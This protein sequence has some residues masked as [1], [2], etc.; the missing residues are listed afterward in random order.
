MTKH[1]NQ[2]CPAERVLR[3]AEFIA[4]KL[5]ELPRV[6]TI[7]GSGLGNLADYIE[8]AI[9]ID[10]S[11]IPNWGQSWIAGHS[12]QLIFGWLD[13]QPVIAM[14]GRFHRY[15]GWTTEQVSFPVRVLAAIGSHT[16]IVSNA[17]GGLNPKYRVGDIVVIRDH[18]DMLHGRPG[19]RF[20]Y[21]IYPPQTRSDA[22]LR[23][24]SPYDQTLSE[25]ALE[26]ARLNGFPAHSG[27]Y[28]ATLGPSY[29]TR[30]EYRFMRKIGADVVGMSTV[31]EVL[32]AQ[33]IGMRVLGMSMV[34]NIARPDAPQRTDHADVL[35]AA[36]IAE[37]RMRAIVREAVQRSTTS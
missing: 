31:P 10:Y 17:A 11:D 6:A 30:A 28:L 34:S 37:P 22:P 5:A 35:A 1:P 4:C 14:S 23:G 33:R 7:L 26:T 36:Q 12:G 27:T 9:A 29:E 32:Q 16:L 18:I 3:T 24:A 25:K 20:D 15:E 21:G 8:D 13:S 19:Q 2:Q